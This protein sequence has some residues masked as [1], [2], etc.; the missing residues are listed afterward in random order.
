M[1]NSNSCRRKWDDNR[2]TRAL[3][4][5]RRT[6]LDNDNTP[7]YSDRISTNKQKQINRLDDSALLQ[8]NSTN[9]GNS[10][11]LL[12]V[13]KISRDF[14]KN[15]VDVDNLYGDKLY[16]FYHSNDTTPEPQGLLPL[17]G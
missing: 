12:P 8:D 5:P 6:S 13:C 16:Q 2:S 1:L 14:H 7:R 9:I 10:H 11:S 17:R 15:P 3:S 4:P